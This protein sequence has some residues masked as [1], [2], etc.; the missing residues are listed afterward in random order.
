MINYLIVLVIFTYRSVKYL[1][2]YT[3]LI[4]F[5]IICYA[6][7]KKHKVIFVSNNGC[8]VFRVNCEMTIR[9]RALSFYIRYWLI[10][11]VFLFLIP[12]A[13]FF[14]IW[15]N[16]LFCIRFLPRVDSSSIFKVKFL[17][18]RKQKEMNLEKC[19]NS[20]LVDWKEG[21]EDSQLIC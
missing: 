5:S 12:F 15:I 6:A 14:R 9:D 3:L 1:S 7:T 21:I 19:N 18:E 13:V 20:I 2:I 8:I 10:E 17:I 11:W 4:V 16:I